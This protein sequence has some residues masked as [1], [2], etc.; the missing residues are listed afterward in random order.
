MEPAPASLLG[1][2]HLHAH[3]GLTHRCFRK[4]QLPALWHF[5]F[6]LQVEKSL[7]DEIHNREETVCGRYQTAFAPSNIELVQQVRRKVSTFQ[8]QKETNPIPLTMG[9]D[10]ERGNAF[11]VNA[12]SKSRAAESCL[13]Q[14]DISGDG[15][16]PV[17]G[18]TKQEEA[19][20]S[21][22]LYRSWSRDGEWQHACEKSCPALSRTF[23]LSSHAW[24]CLCL[25][26]HQA[27]LALL[28]V[29]KNHTRKLHAYWE[30][31]FPSAVWTSEFKFKLYLK[32]W[33]EK[34]TQSEL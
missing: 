21:F 4:K 7:Q 18:Q 15:H 13:T 30:Y 25:A 11:R 27:L 26:P 8:A 6:C 14:A 24:Y 23:T 17:A 3:W 19:L 16:S 20:P 22:P 29:G 5:S 12:I 9:R 31:L 1:Y 2:L 34:S 33:I 32:Q 10:S 28:S